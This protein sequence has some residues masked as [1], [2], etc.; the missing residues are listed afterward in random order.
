G[1]WSRGCARACTGRLTRHDRYRG[2]VIAEHQHVL[3]R[4][5]SLR[6]LGARHGI[7]YQVMVRR[8]IADRVGI[9]GVPRQQ[10]RLAAAA[11]EVLDPLGTAPARLLHPGFA[12]ETIERIRVV[13]DG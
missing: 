10:V 11:T 7:R 6:A 4:R 2:A 3:T 13:P 9:G 1:L 8:E 5:H 12:S